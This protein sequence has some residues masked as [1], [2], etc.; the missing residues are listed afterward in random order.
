M[1]RLLK[2]KKNPAFPRNLHS[3]QQHSPDACSSAQ[4][5]GTASCAWSCWPGQPRAAPVVPPQQMHPAGQTSRTRPAGRRGDGPGPG[6][7]CSRWLWSV[8]HQSAEKKRT[9]TGILW[10]LLL[11][12]GLNKRQCACCIKCFPSDT[13]FIAFPGKSIALFSPPVTPP[14]PITLQPPVA[15]PHP[16]QCQSCFSQQLSSELSFCSHS[17]WQEKSRAACSPEQIFCNSVS[18]TGTILPPAG[19]SS[20]CPS[21]LV[22]GTAVTGQVAWA[23]IRP[24]EP[25]GAKTVPRASHCHCHPSTNCS[26]ATARGEY[27]F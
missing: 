3:H 20:H 19:R 17:P 2:S 15:L 26:L 5:L 6:N 11:R 12:E 9:I 10:E 21:P 24:W 8:P 1:Q 18:R 27:S 7:S 14:S 13:T 16:L 22:R 25:L 23:A 4:P